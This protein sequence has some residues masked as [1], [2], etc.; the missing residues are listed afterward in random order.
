[1]ATKPPSLAH[2]NEPIQIC[3]T[4]KETPL[5]TGVIM[6]KICVSM[7]NNTK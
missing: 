4:A 6:L 5:E 1:M 3:S 2:V 7:P